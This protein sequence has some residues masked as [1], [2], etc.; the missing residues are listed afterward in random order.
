MQIDGRI[1]LRHVRSFCEISRLG[2]FKKAADA[3][4][5]TAPAISRTMAELEEMVGAKLLLR[6]RGG[7]QLTAEGTVFLHFAQTGLNAIQ[8]GMA[9]LDQMQAGEL[10]TVRIGALPSVAAGLL[11]RA[12]QFLSELAPGAVMVEDG[13]HEYLVER[14]RRGQLDVVVGR[15]GPPETMG[16]VSFTQLYLEHVAFVVRPGHPLEAVGDVARIAAGPV[17]YPPANAAIRPLVDRLMLANGVTDPPRAVES[18]SGAFGRSLTLTSDA[19]WIISTGVVA[20]DLEAG[21]LSRL[22]VDAQLTAGPV[23]LME[24]ADEERVPAVRVFGRA[25]AMALDLQRSR[26]SD[27]A[28]KV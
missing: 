13:P 23:G 6:D 20:Q 12:V 15:L 22:P 1:K 11:P 17:I 18:V 19:V 26:D 24:R 4:A 7:V 10:T 27:E 8:Q 5:L 28:R 2:S 14:L 21:R 16:G 25:L 9:R 3:L